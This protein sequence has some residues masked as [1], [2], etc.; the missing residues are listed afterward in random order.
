MA[1]QCDVHG[2]LDIWEKGLAAGSAA[3]VS[4]LVANPLELVKVNLWGCVV[5]H[6]A[7]R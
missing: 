3:V 2:Q 7:L 5:Y 1:N 4:T 6:R